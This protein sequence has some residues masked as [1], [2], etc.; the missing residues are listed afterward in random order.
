MARQT[1]AELR[2]IPVTPD[3]LLDWQK[4]ES[5]IDAGVKLVAVTQVSNALGTLIDIPRIVSLAKKV[6]AKVLVD[7]AQAAAHIPVN[8]K[9]LDID[10]YACSAHKMLGPMGVGAL[11]IRQE[12]LDSNEFRPV[13]F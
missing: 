2:M 8:F 12:L 10:F 11:L 9:D 13:F 5:L 7:G 3:G 1:G 4:F 6:G